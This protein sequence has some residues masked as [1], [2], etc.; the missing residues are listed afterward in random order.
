MPVSVLVPVEFVPTGKD[1]GRVEPGFGWKRMVHQ[2]T[3]GHQFIH[4]E[5]A[6]SVIVRWRTCPEEMSVKRKDFLNTIS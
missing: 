3:G 4:Q 6:V 5:L 2:R 1:G